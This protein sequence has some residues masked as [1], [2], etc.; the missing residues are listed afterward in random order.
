MKCEG[1]DNRCRLHDE[2]A[3]SWRQKSE[4]SNLGYWS[5]IDRFRLKGPFRWPREISYDYAV[6]LSI[7]QWYHLVLRSFLPPEL[8]EFTK[9][10]WWR[11]QV[12]CSQCN[13][14]P[15]WWVLGDVRNSGTK[16]DL[17]MERVLEYEEGEH[18]ARFFVYFSAFGSRSQGM[19]SY[20]E[21]SAKTSHNVDSAFLELATSLK[22]QHDIGAHLDAHSTTDGFHLGAGGTSIVGRS[23]QDC[24][25][26]IW[27]AHFFLL[28]LRS[29]I[30]K[31][32]ILTK[33]G[34][35]Y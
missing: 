25:R 33:W 19:F 18:L 22:R 10:D 2:N 6:V 9:M 26:F 12:C 29:A 16:C 28:L 34:A 4:A 24:C 3:R 17:E 1:N 15:R 30:F 8:R 11:E 21:T 13:Q 31:L 5:V 7:R 27:L 14:N 23:W 32:L 35:H 20:V